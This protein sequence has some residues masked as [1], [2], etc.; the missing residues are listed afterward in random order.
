MSCNL[1]KEP[2]KN[3]RQE[4]EVGKQ[5]KNVF[6]EFKVEIIKQNCS[7][8]DSATTKIKNLRGK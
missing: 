4:T 1:E 8:R 7:G 5:P 3:C 2:I 6:L